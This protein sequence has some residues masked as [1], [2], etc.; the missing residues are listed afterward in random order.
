MVGSGGVIGSLVTLLRLRSDTA[1]TTVSVA[2]GAVIVQAGVID[3]LKDENARLHEKCAALGKA[4][5][6]IDERKT[7]RGEP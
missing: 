5:A 6:A 4:L 7:A 2:E 3:S 1:R